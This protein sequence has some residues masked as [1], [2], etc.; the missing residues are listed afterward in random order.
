MTNFS[1]GR[2]AEEAAAD[3]LKQKRYNIVEQNWRTRYCEID[4]VVKRKKKVM[5]VE[6]KYRKTSQ[7]GS[8]LEYITPQKL[9]QMAFAAEMW[10][11]TN[12]WKHDYSLG[13]VEVSGPEYQISNFLADI[14]VQT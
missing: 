1:H 5:F 7:Q 10:V 12:G 4:L 8:G 14:E 9:R 13:A 6:V 2:I 3:F 11:Q